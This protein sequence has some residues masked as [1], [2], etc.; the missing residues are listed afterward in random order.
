MPHI[1]SQQEEGVVNNDFIFSLKNKGDQS[2]KD[3]PATVC[4]K[5]TITLEEGLDGTLYV[6][7][8]GR[9]LKVLTL[10]E[11]PKKAHIPFV[12]VKITPLMRKPSMNLPWRTPFPVKAFQSTRS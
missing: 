5:D 9:E 7:L 1:L 4:K 3:Q 2:T 12:I 11:R 6:R 10:P 8:R